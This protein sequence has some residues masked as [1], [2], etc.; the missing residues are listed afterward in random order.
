MKYTIITE[1]QFGPF[2]IKKKY[3]NVK[4]HGWPQ[5]FQNKSIMLLE[6]IYGGRR[7][8]DVSNYENIYIPGESMNIFNYNQNQQQPTQKPKKQYLTEGQKKLLK[9][10]NIEDKKIN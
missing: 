2:T 3:K 8:I 6:D 7:F 10:N 4:F 1:K 9:E 5:N